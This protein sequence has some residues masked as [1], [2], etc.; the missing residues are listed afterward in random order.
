MINRNSERFPLPDNSSIEENSFNSFDSSELT[1][2]KIPFIKK[3][4]RN[5]YYITPGNLSW[6]DK[7]YDSPIRERVFKNPVLYFSDSLSLDT[8]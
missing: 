4:G 6:Q 8:S 7:F 2:S 3:I 5:D 1:G